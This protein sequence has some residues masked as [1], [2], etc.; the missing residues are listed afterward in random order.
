MLRTETIVFLK[1]PLSIVSG[2][3]NASATSV[4]TAGE[5]S[6][7]L[8]EQ[9]QHIATLTNQNQDSRAPARQNEPT[10]NAPQPSAAGANAADNSGNLVN[11]VG[12]G[13]EVSAENNDNR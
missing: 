7:E 9:R 5:L 6:R 3:Y 8:A 2:G 12:V 4:M 11:V 10:T 1:L 13:P